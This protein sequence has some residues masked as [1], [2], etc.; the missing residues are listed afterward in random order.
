[1]LTNKIF[2]AS[3]LKKPVSRRFRLQSA[4][5]LSLVSR[6]A[7]CSRKV[8]RAQWQ[9]SLVVRLYT[10]QLYDYTPFSCTTIYL[11]V[12]RLYAFQLYDYIPFSCTTIYLLVVRLYTIQLYNYTSF[13]RMT[14]L[15]FEKKMGLVPPCFCIVS[16]QLMV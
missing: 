12:V 4:A 3:A 10:F 11:L 9:P 14:F 5:L 1:M 7:D 6:F 15:Y 8:C 13:G 16:K 2:N